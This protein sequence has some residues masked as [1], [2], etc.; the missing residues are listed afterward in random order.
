MKIQC[1]NKY[2]DFVSAKKFCK[3]TALH[4]NLEVRFAWTDGAIILGN[5]HCEGVLGVGSNQTIC[6]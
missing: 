5:R 1:V 2:Y 3:E 4:Y 6:P